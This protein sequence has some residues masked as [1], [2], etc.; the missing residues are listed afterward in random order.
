MNIKKKYPII[1]VFLSSILL[2]G[3]S[4]N[5]PENEATAES[6]IEAG[7]VVVPH[8]PLVIGIPVV[9]K[10]HSLYRIFCLI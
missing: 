6:E 9:D 7:G 1:L 2:I 8:R 3:C 4:G 5:I 10:P